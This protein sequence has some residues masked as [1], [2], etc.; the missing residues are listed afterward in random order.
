MPCL[1]TRAQIYQ[2]ELSVDFV[3]VIVI[4]LCYISFL[5]FQIMRD[6]SRIPE[7][8][9]KEEGDEACFELGAD[10]SQT[11]L[12][13]PPPPPTHKAVLEEASKLRVSFFN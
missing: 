2:G 12:S 3:A 10:L 13:E 7:P 6:I 8:D 4:M 9:H 5:Q 1:R 11:Q